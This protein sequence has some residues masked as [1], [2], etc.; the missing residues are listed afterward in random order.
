MR[1]PGAVAMRTSAIDSAT[2]SRLPGICRVIPISVSV[3][4]W[5]S[6][7]RQGS[8]SPRAPDTGPHDRARVR[9]LTSAATN[10]GLDGPVAGLGFVIGPIRRQTNDVAGLKIRELQPIFSY[11][12]GRKQIVFAIFLLEGFE[13]ILPGEG[14]F[15]LLLDRTLDGDFLRALDNGGDDRAAGKVPAIQIIMATTAIGDIEEA[16]RIRMGVMLFDDVIDHVVAFFGKR[17]FLG[18]IDLIDLAR[19]FLVRTPH[20]NLAVD[21]AGTEDGRVDQVSAIGRDDDDDIV[22]RFQTVHLGAEHRHEGGQYAVPDA[23]RLA[24]AEDR[25][26]FVDE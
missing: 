9:L 14:R 2:T 18:E 24:R 13:Q 20:A 26:R 11:I 16:I 1:T 22:Q 5:M 23:N 8:G 3:P 12:A 19:C 21:T 4:N 10:L 6:I 17:K 7:N 15:F 25:F